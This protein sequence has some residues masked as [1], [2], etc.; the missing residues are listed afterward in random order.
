ME[1]TTV[2]IGQ[3]EQLAMDTAPLTNED[4]IRKALEQMNRI[5]EPTWDADYDERRD[6][7]Y[8]RRRAAGPALSYFSPKVAGMV[9]RLDV[10]TG[11]LTGIDLEDFRR[12]MAV[13]IPELGEVLKVRR[14]ARWAARL[15]GLRTLARYA[16]RGVD[17][18]TREQVRARYCLNP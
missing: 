15:P 10:Q 17:A 1:A 14:R 7:M 5:I 3:E 8:L 9:F 11:E 6:T 4:G 13:Q 16:L 18:R 2:V 12:V